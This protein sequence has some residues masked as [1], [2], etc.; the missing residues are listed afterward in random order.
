MVQKMKYY[1]EKKFK[2][3]TR[4]GLELDET[5]DEKKKHEEEKAKFEP[6]SKLMQD[7]LRD[8]VEKVVIGSRN[9]ESTFVLETSE[10]L[11]PR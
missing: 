3:F 1:E 11:I 6:L 4:E 9:D 10:G 5:R 8:K 7:I 2:S